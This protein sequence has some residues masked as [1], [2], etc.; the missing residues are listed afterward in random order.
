MTTALG[1]IGGALVLI[2]FVSAMLELTVENST[3]WGRAAPAVMGLGAAVLVLGLVA[4]GVA[5]W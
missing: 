1:I 5:R 4:F 3:A 2:G